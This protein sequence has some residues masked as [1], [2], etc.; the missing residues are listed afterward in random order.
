MF[1]C[2]V[3]SGQQVLS[4]HDAS[5]A[6]AL[7]NEKLYNPPVFNTEPLIQ[8]KQSD[9]LSSFTRTPPSISTNQTYLTFNTRKVITFDWLFPFSSKEELTE[10]KN[11][12]IESTPSEKIMTSTGYIYISEKSDSKSSAP[13]MQSYYVKSSRSYEDQELLVPLHNSLELYPEPSVSHAHSTS[14]PLNK[15][16][17][18]RSVTTSPLSPSEASDSTVTDIL[19][20]TRINASAVSNHHVYSTSVS[21]AATDERH[22]TALIIQKPHYL[23]EVNEDGPA[24][25]NYN[26]NNHWE[27]GKPEDYEAVSEACNTEHW[28]HLKGIEGE[29]YKRYE[30]KPQT[31]KV[32]IDAANHFHLTGSL[33]G[34]YQ[35]S[36][37]DK[38]EM[39]EILKKRGEL[40]IYGQLDEQ[41]KQGEWFVRTDLCSLKGTRPIIANG[42]E[43]INGNRV[44]KSARELYLS[45]PTADVTKHTPIKPIGY[46]GMKG[47]LPGKINLYLFPWKKLNPDK[48]FRVFVHGGRVT[49]ISQQN[50]YQRNELLMNM[51]LEE[52]Q[53]QVEKWARQIIEYV[54]KTVVPSITH[55]S[56]YSIDLAI[57]ETDDDI[58]FIELNPFG[59][60]YSS[61]S[62]LFHWI[63]DEK[64]LYGQQQ[65]NVVYF[66]YTIESGQ[67]IPDQADQETAEEDESE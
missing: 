26:S 40:N 44:Y 19:L 35:E 3:A 17:G 51:P 2:S 18:T 58:Y 36:V 28:V 14:L 31:V 32:M 7:K 34:D 56:S 49:A 42:E 45:L 20:A 21:V 54:H 33:S 29:D 30:L 41:L 9:Y 60:Q 13:P 64:I 52:R 53:T 65:E 50:L 23:H 38:E 48:E 6:P 62:A 11:S 15:L 4:D 39:M 8:S 1:W 22:K 63:K 46:D 67:V 43:V 66:R 27:N 59:K 37:E 12:D 5:H 16:A 47:E 24:R 61:G 55:T 10:I 25:R 57:N